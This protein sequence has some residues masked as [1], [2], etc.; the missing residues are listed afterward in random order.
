V[1]RVS[2][3]GEAGV[4]RALRGLRVDTED[5]RE[6]FNNIANDTARMAATLAPS[7][8]GALRASIR[9]NSTK[10]RAVVSVGSAKVPYAARVNYGPRSTRRLFLQKADRMIRP[11]LVRRVEVGLNAAI[12]RRGLG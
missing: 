5:L 11:T 3:H 7:R 8:S 2:V 10:N 12:M 6:V 4:I 1:I 9:G